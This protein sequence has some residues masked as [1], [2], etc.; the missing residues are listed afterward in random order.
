M[1]Y[2]VDTLVFD[3]GERYPILMGVN[4]M[5]HF[6]TTLWVTAKLRSTMA[7]NTIISRLGAVNWFLQ[8]EKIEGRDLYSEF[9]CGKF[10][11]AKDIDSIK[12][13]LAIDVA[14]LKGISKKKILGI[15]W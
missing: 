10:L 3:N 14:H 13:H 11:D 7:V 2:K 15:K 5:P 6:Y 1:E 8:W 4:E 9:K 12:S